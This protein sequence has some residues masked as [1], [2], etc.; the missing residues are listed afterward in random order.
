MGKD[1]FGPHRGPM[2]RFEPFTNEKCSCD[3][4]QVDGQTCRECGGTGKVPI[5][6]A[7]GRIGDFAVSRTAERE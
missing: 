6:R 2:E 1:G 4:G 5:K 3:N 7:K